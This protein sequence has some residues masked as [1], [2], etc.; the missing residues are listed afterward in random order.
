MKS[1]LLIDF[2]DL[3]EDTWSISPSFSYLLPPSLFTLPSWYWHFYCYTQDSSLVGKQPRGL[4]CN[5]TR[6][7][8]KKLSTLKAWQIMLTIRAMIRKTWREDSVF[9]RYYQKPEGFACPVLLGVSD[10][11]LLYNVKSLAGLPPPWTMQLFW[12]L[13]GNLSDSLPPLSKSIFFNRN[14][15]QLL[16]PGW[17][18]PPAHCTDGYT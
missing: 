4:K 18:P 2:W 9:L 1:F 5:T 7:F 11:M 8:V 6:A 17:A 14:G 12:L 10:T 13:W 16:P 15:C 3:K